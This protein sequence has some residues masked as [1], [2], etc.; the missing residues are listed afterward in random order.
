[1]GLCACARHLPWSLCEQAWCQRGLQPRIR[2]SIGWN[3][4]SESASS[5][6]IRINAP[7]SQRDKS[8]REAQSRPRSLGRCPS[9][10]RH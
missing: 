5:T 3:V 10:S 1:M 6:Q 4:A 2:A 9:C 7:I 8:R